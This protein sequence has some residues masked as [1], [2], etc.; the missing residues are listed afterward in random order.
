MTKTKEVM[1]ALRDVVVAAGIPAANMKVGVP[2]SLTGNVTGFIT[3]GP[4]P[5]ASKTTQTFVR[6]PR[7]LVILGYFVQAAEQAAEEQ[8]ADHLDNIVVKMYEDRT[9]GGMVNSL[10]LDLSGADAPEYRIYAGRMYRLYPII[11]EVTWQ[12]HYGS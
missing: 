1:L 6:R 7:F 5:N 9:L 10:F 3:I 8:I 2:A 11:V 4:Q 12:E